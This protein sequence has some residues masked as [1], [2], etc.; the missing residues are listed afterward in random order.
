MRRLSGLRSASSYSVN[1]S[2]GSAAGSSTTALTSSATRARSTRPPTRSA[3]ST[4]AASSSAGAIAGDRHRRLVDRRAEALDGERAIVEVGAQGGH[5]PQPAVGGR[6]GVHHAVEERPLILLTGQGEQLLELVDDQQQLAV[7]GHERGAPP[8]RCHPRR[9]RARRPSRSVSATAT[10]RRLS[11]SSLNGE[12][13][14]SIVV[15]NHCARPGNV[16][17]TDPRQQPGPHDAGLA[18]PRT[19]DDQHEPCPQVVA[20]EPGEDLVDEV[21]TAEEVGGV[22]LVERPQPLVRV[23]ERLGARRARRR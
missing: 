12:E 19:A 1:C 4:I 16:P 9:R 6:D 3:G 13:P 5:H 2:D 10:R 23:R 11:A 17:A 7:A 15:T 18:R 14:G 20:A 8:D 21:G 22:G